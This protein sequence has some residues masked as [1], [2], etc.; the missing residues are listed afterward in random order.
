M[1]RFSRGDKTPRVR[2][3]QKIELDEKNIPLRLL[4]VGL[5]IAI[6]VACIGWG[7]SKLLSTEAGWKVI[8]VDC[9]TVNCS[10]DFILNYDFTDD[11][12][13]ATV[14]QRQLVSLYSDAC[15]KAHWLFTTDEAAKDFGNMFAVNQ[16]VNQ[17]VSVDPVLYEA[18]ELLKQKGSRELYLAPVYAVYDDLIVSESDVMA[19][20][21]DPEQNPEMDAY[22]AKIAEFAGNPNMI[23]LE[24]LGGHQV[25]LKV[26]DAYLTFAEE[27]EISVFVDF[28]WMTNA[29]ITDYLADLLLENGF[30]TGYI[31]S[32]D[33]FT[34][35]LDNRNQ[36]Y[37]VNIF[38]RQGEQAYAAG[39]MI[40]RS[41]ATL[42]SL[43]DYPL[44]DRDQWS[45]YRWND[46]HLT[47]TFV[48]ISD[49]HSKAAV[50]TLLTYTYGKSCG[51]VLL[52]ML[53]VYIAD[54][55]EEGKLNA[56]AKQGMYSVWCQDR[57]VCYNEAGLEIGS[58]FEKDDVRYTTRYAGK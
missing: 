42:V 33:G 44:S 11:G 4:L 5:C 48:D 16:A 31:A 54:S 37:S 45:Y 32:R 30:S 47:N 3:V 26:S 28:H 7:M 22:V 49:G 55:L 24:L 1:S 36:A 18:F 50:D 41:G 25:R 17:T 14:R 6:A 53:D 10:Q 2:P 57:V 8:E 27:N 46:G 9:E 38:N 56:L 15:E 12:Q 21:F 29:F 23:D 39:E 40:Y 20:E 52:E 13:S 51:E 43:R 19:A 58:L 35:N 34:R